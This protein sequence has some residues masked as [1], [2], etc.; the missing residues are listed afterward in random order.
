M[1][2]TETQSDPLIEEF[3]T[4][5]VGFTH[6]EI[7]RATGVSR[8]QIRAIVW[9]ESRNPG[10]ATL[11]S[12]VDGLKKLRSA[13]ETGQASSPVACPERPEGEQPPC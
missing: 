6:T 8:A 9:G 13:T 4:L 3:R 11:R 5:A 7:S 12:L 2:K 10:I 1:E